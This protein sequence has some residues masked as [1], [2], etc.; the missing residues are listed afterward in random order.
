MIKEALQYLVGLKDNKTYD[1]DG[2]TYS[3]N[4]LAIIEP[5]R[6]YRKTIQFGSLDAIVKMVKAEIA[7]YTDGTEPVFIQ[8]KDYKRV[9]VFTRPDDQERRLL[10]YEAECDDAEFREGWRSQ[11]AAIIELK[12]RFIPTDDSEY[13]INLISRIN[14][15][16]GVQSTDNGVSQIVVTKQGVTLVG[17]ESVKPR[18]KLQPFRTF[19]EVPQPVSEFILRVDDQKGIGLFEADGGIWNMEA[20]D[21]IKRY[22]EEN[23]AEEISM[24]AVIVMV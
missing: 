12:S 1:I 15:D 11:Q 18:L 24:G 7:D 16:Q 23:L 5:P 4:P 6:F 13:L 19:R 10:P 8:V 22:F 21:N 3:D 20:K 14:S 2:K 9:A 17:S